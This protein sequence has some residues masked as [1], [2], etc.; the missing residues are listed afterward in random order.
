MMKPV[1]WIHP[2]WWLFLCLAFYMSSAGCARQD[3]A[4]SKNDLAIQVNNSRIT[5]SEFNEQFKFEAWADPELDVTK[6]SRKRFVDYLV[7]KELMIQTAVDLQLDR[8]DAFVKAIEKYWESTLVKT[9]LDHKT[10]ELKKG[11]LVSREEMEAYYLTHKDE[12]GQPFEAVKD[13]IQ[14]ILESRRLEKELSTWIKELKASSDIYIN[15][16]VITN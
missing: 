1:S 10:R 14:S 3:Q 9:L 4:E 15:E 6:E 7:Q 11:I 5:V 16:A 2:V 8:E 13:S 12:L